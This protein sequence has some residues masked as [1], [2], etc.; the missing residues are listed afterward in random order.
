MVREIVV[1]CTH[2]Q[3][4]AFF[5]FEIPFSL[6]GIHEDQPVIL[7]NRTW[8]TYGDIVTALENM[9]KKKT[10][11][12]T[13]NEEWLNPLIM[14]G[15]QIGLADLMGA[16]TMEDADL[17][18]AY[19]AVPLNREDALR[20]VFGALQVQSNMTA[21]GEDEVQSID[22]WVKMLGNVLLNEKNAVKDWQLTEIQKMRILEDVFDED[23]LDLLEDEEK[24]LFQK[25]L[26]D[27]CE[28][29]VIH[30]WRIKAYYLCTDNSVY[31]M[32][33]ESAAGIFESL[34]EEEGDPMDAEMLG[35]ILYKGL[36]EGEDPDY[37]NAYRYFTIGA[38]SGLHLSMCYCADMLLKGQ[39]VTANV[40]AAAKLVSS[41]YGETKELFTT[42]EI[43]CCFP[44]A[45]VRMGD[46]QRFGIGVIA[47]AMLA[48]SYYL[49]AMNGLSMRMQLMHKRDD[50]ELYQEIMERLKQ[51]EE[52]LG[53][54]VRQPVYKTEKPYMIDRLLSNGCEL[55]MQVKREDH[56]TSLVFNRD[57]GGYL[58]LTCEEIGYCRLHRRV[59]LK[60]VNLR[61]PV[62]HHQ[63]I[64][65]DQVGYDDET[66]ETV[67]LRR[68]KIVQRL[69]CDYYVFTDH[70]DPQWRAEPVLNFAAA[71]FPGEKKEY[72]FICSIPG[73]KRGDHIL[74]DTKYGPEEA[75]LLR[76]YPARMSEMPPRRYRRVLQK[77]GNYLYA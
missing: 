14:L 38:F 43:D 60:T 8:I 31:D 71:V 36:I 68:G 65:F 50:K 27:E 77:M 17:E 72:S 12:L 52:A 5:R 49:E 15:D 1:N 57:D 37:E 59:R 46:Y 30:A 34:C 63:T 67:F 19:L 75:V 29:G 21:N 4:K 69:K 42:G 10:G 25:C 40:G 23:K 16:E 11:I 47:D 9:Q 26:N 6:L 2:Q 54:K 76:E 73:L 24:A 18:H 55:L 61:N 66:G 56:E 74:V 62:M 28:A 51:C 32:D 53:E 35:T 3:L 22:E 58:L 64:R 70:R 33:Y 45:A 20:Y 7:K 41:A 48:Y 39:G 44:E 13:I